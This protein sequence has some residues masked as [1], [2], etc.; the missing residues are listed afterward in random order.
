[1]IQV[2]IATCVQHKILMIGWDMGSQQPG[3]QYNTHLSLPCP[4]IRAD[5][6]VSA[7]PGVD[8]RL[9]PQVDVTR[10]LSRHNARFVELSEFQP[11]LN[12][13]LSADMPPS[14]TLIPAAMTTH[15]CPAVHRANRWILHTRYVLCYT[16]WMLIYLYQARSHCCVPVL[17]CKPAAAAAVAHPYRCVCSL[18]VCSALTLLPPS[19]GHPELFKRTRAHP[20]L[21]APCETTRFISPRHVVCVGLYTVPCNLHSWTHTSSH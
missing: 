7:V 15:P 8:A 11:A 2:L 6:Q 19:C 3:V 20:Y 1:M 9:G 13:V 4:V 18:L 5:Q 21:V 14:L 10:R 17:G 16:P 12:K